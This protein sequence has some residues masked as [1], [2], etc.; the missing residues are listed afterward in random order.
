MF[1]RKRREA[2]R[3]EIS[4]LV[5]VVFLLLIFFMVSTRFTEAPAVEIQLPSADGESVAVQPELPRLAV[6]ESNRIFLNDEEIPIDE[7]QA[8]LQSSFDGS[9]AERL[10]NLNA[11]RKAD[12]QTMAAV[13]DACRKAGVI[14]ATALTDPSA[15]PA[16]ESQ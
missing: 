4:S 8:H 3:I 14:T 16:H 9:D 13:F 5:D 12:W 6:D 10:V 2:P 7:L 15:G 1:A 11:D